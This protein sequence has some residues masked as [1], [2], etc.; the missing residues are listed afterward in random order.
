MF[1]SKA[2]YSQKNLATLPSAPPRNK[3]LR[4]LKSGTAQ[5]RIITPPAVCLKNIRPFLRMEGGHMKTAAF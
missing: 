4:G 2:G 3:K 5:L 1:N